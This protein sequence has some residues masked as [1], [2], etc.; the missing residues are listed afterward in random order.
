MW[1][2]R[3]EITLTIGILVETTLHALLKA[4][5]RLKISLEPLIM[6]ECVY[7]Y[8]W[9]MVCII[10]VAPIESGLVFHDCAGLWYPVQ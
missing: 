4:I 5:N 7:I 10:I 8:R 6:Q 9:Y 3:R 2:I 1:L